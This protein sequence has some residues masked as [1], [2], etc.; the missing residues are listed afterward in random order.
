MFHTLLP[1]NG[2]PSAELPGAKFSATWPALMST[3]PELSPP[4]WVC[5]VVNV[6]VPLPFCTSV[7]FEPLMVLGIVTL[8][9]RLKTNV[10]LLRLITLEGESEPLVPPA[11]SCSV[12]PLIVVVPM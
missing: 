1:P 2:P 7:K 9:P 8:S 11:P 3:V 12:P 6:V 4:P 10:A 5:C